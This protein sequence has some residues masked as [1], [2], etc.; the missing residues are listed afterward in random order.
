VISETRTPEVI[1]VGV[2]AVIPKGGREVVVQ[3]WQGIAFKKH[4]IRLLDIWNDNTDIP[5]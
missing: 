5:A 2:T 1:V 3:R 4:E